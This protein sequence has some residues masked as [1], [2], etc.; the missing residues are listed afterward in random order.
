M[1]CGVHV[2]QVQSIAVEVLLRLD[3]FQLQGAA[4]AQETSATSAPKIADV[5]GWRLALLLIGFATVT[6]ILERSF[7]GL[8]KLLKSRH[9]LSTALSH[10]KNEL[11]FVG[12]ISLLLSAFQ[13]DLAK[14]CIPKNLG[15][16]YL[17]PVDHARRL[18][19]TGR[20]LLAG[21]NVNY[22]GD[23]KESLWPVSLQHDAHIFIF[24]VACTHIVYG[25]ITVYTTLFRVKTWRKWE[26]EA[27]AQR[28]EYGDVNVMQ[29]SAKWLY[30]NVGSN[31]VAHWLLMFV[32]QWHISVDQTLYHNAR[33]VFIEKMRLSYDFDFH[34][35]VV[36]SLEMELMRTLRPEW[37]MWLIAVVWYAVP[38]P[39]YISFW[40]YG[41]ALVVLLA[42]GSKLV[43]ILMH[44]SVQLAIKYRGSV[45]YGRMDDDPLASRAFQSLG[46]SS[47]RENPTPQRREELSRVRKALVGGAA[48]RRDGAAAAAGTAAAGEALGLRR[49]RADLVL[50]QLSSREE[51]VQMLRSWASE[52]SG[53]AGD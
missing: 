15:E 10:V 29:V 13:N 11:L 53:A 12:S 21:G 44:I 1:K 42:I 52:R 38:P 30:W 28:R 34:A 40:M 35:L 31:P 51:A 36:R 24:V 43:D 20:Q 27:Q 50:R 45:L 19:A 22:C 32:R 18:L 8:H 41:I 17:S 3:A 49:A 26:L 33:L 46:R 39:A 4:M 16:A 6:V 23:S 25:T 7:E 47:L 37:H 9:G 5:Q 14:I 48:G 2:V